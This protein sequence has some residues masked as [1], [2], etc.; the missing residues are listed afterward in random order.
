M[1]IILRVPH[2][3]DMVF[4]SYEDL[5]L[6]WKV[7]EDYNGCQLIVV[8]DEDE[9]E[10]DKQQEIKENIETVADDDDCAVL[11]FLVPKSVTF[12]QRFQDR[13]KK[14]II[15]ILD[16]VYPNSFSIKDITYNDIDDDSDNMKMIIRIKAVSDS[17]TE[18]LKYLDKNVEFIMNDLINYYL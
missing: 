2:Y 1:K 4:E 13:V 14:E 9:E 6:I 18:N 11:S 7:I 17:G 12:T 10:F 15:E 16:S 3:S 8:D 5:N